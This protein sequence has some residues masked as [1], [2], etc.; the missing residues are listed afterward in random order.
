MK[1]DTAPSITRV[2]TLHRIRTVVNYVNE[3]NRR[4]VPI[5]DDVAIAKHLIETHLSKPTTEL[6]Q[7]QIGRRARDHLE[8]ARYLGFLIR[9]K[10]SRRFTHLPTIYGKLLAEY[11]YED[12]CPKD[13]FEE[14]LFIDRICRMKL[15]NVSY[16]QTPRLYDKYRARICLN[17][18]SALQTNGNTLSVFQLATFLSTPVLDPFF[19]SKEIKQL[20]N[21]VSS[22]YYKNNYLKKLSTNDIRNIKRDTLPFID[23]C[24]Q[25]DLL[26]RDETSVQLTSRGNDILNFYSNMFPLWWQDFNNLPMVP[27]AI[28][29]IV[30][31]LKIRSQLDKIDA[32]LDKSINWKLFNLPI[33]ETLKS[34]LGSKFHYINDPD[35]LFDFSYEY[36]VPP[37]F[38]NETRDL[39]QQLLDK[40]EIQ[41]TASC[42]IK[43]TELYC[44]KTI[45][46]LLYKESRD[47]RKQIKQDQ[48]I[49]LKHIPTSILSQLKSP[50]EATTYIHFKAIESDNF[51]IDKYQA[52]LSDFF[53]NDPTYNNFSKN[54]PDFLL[55]NDFYGLIECKSV[56]EWG[57]ILRLRKSVIAE[58]EFYN[59]YCATLNR[60]G[61]RKRCTVIICYEGTI[62]DEDKT[63]IITLLK[64]KYP[65]VIIMT[66]QY[67]QKALIDVTARHKFIS[68]VKGEDADNYFI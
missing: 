5:V 28:I 20:C 60:I 12:E 36:D 63:N 49:Y 31:Y 64:T 68:L 51:R 59:N 55:T 32:L 48:N 45:S 61:I 56:S 24:D 18:L 11:R 6:F 54:N 25:V 46:R 9:T 8:T 21:K 30:N 23:W 50:Y 1:I 65:N 22:S 58:I 13:Y 62:R 43:N 39:I 38:H 67:L 57:N 33:K 19:H 35:I 44:I 7:D 27:A 17:M 16:M 66:G 47:R 42:A 15:S 3:L 40:L 53:I 10:K 41:E 4:R 52:Q 2:H 29:I 14:A 37:D 34:I 26:R